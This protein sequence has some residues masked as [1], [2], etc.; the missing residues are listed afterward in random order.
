MLNDIINTFKSHS[1]PDNAVAMSAYMKNHFS[2]F[3]IKSPDRKAISKPFL[4][5]SKHLNKTEAKAL[6]LNLWEEKERELHYLAMEIAEKSFKKS[7]IKETLIF[8][9][10]LRLKTVG[11]TA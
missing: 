8:W 2:F 4:T 1:H 9:L 10:N 6:I 7:G 3:G 11:G 5:Q